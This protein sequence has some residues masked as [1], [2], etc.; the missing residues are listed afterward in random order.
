MWKRIRDYVLPIAVLVLVAHAA[1]GAVWQWSKT[2]GTNATAD[3][4]I[5]WAEGMAPSAVNDSARAMMARLAEWRDDSSGLLAAAG[6]ATA[7]TVTTNQGLN[8]TP[9]DGQALCLTP[10]TTNGVGVTL[11]ADGGTAFAINTDTSTAVPGA[12]L[13]AGTPYCFKFNSSASK[14]ITRSFYGN[15]FN[16]PL[17]SI[18][19]CTCTSAPNSNFV[20]PA[21]QAISRTTFATYFAQVG[22]TYG[23]G[24]GVTTFNVPD[25]TGRVIAGFQSP[26]VRI[27]TAGSGIN[28]AAMGAAGGTQNVNIDQ[29]NFPSGVTLTTTIAAGAGGHSHSVI[30]GISV[31]GGGTLNTISSTANNL[32]DA[33]SIQSAT[34]PLMTG[35]T[36]LG[37]SAV[38][39]NNMP[40]TIILQYILRVF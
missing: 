26:A 36:P 38:A 1:S 23:V 39:L 2:A 13:V 9:T 18:M 33:T 22:T 12:A 4:T 15:P 29:T 3:P 21:G 8:S 17:G 30:G 31:G 28:A 37:G 6:T 11:A 5:N 40:P 14:W 27:T 10:G 19:S 7:Y 34:L 24:D 32:T 20:I 35:T 25:L 16:V